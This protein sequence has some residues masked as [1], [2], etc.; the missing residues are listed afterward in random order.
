MYLDLTCL[1]PWKQEVERYEV[2]KSQTSG[3]EGTS[4]L[5]LIS[6]RSPYHLRTQ[7]TP[8][9]LFHKRPTI[10]LGTWGYFCFRYESTEWSCDQMH[11][12]NKCEWRGEK[13]SFVS[14]PTAPM[15]MLASSACL[16]CSV[17]FP[18]KLLQL[19]RRNNQVI[20]RMLKKCLI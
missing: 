9:A 14:A 12:E 3:S 13:S 10:I 5:P 15:K 4:G 17:L 20:T 6:P 18:G 11:S 16:G 7:I 8:Q 1:P 19:R 2:K